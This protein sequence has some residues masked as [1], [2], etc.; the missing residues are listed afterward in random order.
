MQMQY[1]T[2]NCRAERDTNRVSR[3]LV[4][5][6]C[7]QNVPILS[8]AVGLTIAMYSISAFAQGGPIQGTLTD[9]TGAVIPGASTHLV[10]QATSVAA[11]T[12]SNSVGLYQVPDLFS[13]AYTIAAP[14]MKTYK[15][16]VEFLV[17]QSH[18]VNR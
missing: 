15:T 12:K 9:S 4:N 14:G 10:N 18:G 2:E 7:N 13:G 5:I 1:E 16:S 11:D 17:A 6:L 8:I 3:N